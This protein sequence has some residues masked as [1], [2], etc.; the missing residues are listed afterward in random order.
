MET[1]LNCIVKSQSDEIIDD[2][3]FS[4]NKD[5]YNELSLNKTPYFVFEQLINKARTNYEE[6]KNLEVDHTKFLYMLLNKK[7]YG[8]INEKN[9]KYVYKRIYCFK[10][11]QYRYYK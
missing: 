1:S 7:K 5:I 9:V 4:L 8:K 2:L 6:F 3:N 10:K 11:I